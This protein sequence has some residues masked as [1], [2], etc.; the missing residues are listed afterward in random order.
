MDGATR[1]FH[2]IRDGAL[3]VPGAT[4]DDINAVMIMARDAAIDWRKRHRGRKLSVSMREKCVREAVAAVRNVVEAR[5]VLAVLRSEIA[6]LR[7]TEDGACL[8]SHETNETLDDVPIAA[9]RALI[10]QGLLILGGVGEHEADCYV[11]VPAKAEV[12]LQ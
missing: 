9:A 3:E 8:V 1:M 7:Y 12:T 11:A 4:A 6:F 2:Q 10:D 5:R